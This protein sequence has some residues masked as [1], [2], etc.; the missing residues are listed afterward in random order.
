MALSM[1]LLGRLWSQNYEGKRKKRCGSARTVESRKWD[2]GPR[3]AVEG[4]G[5]PHYRGLAKIKPTGPLRLANQTGWRNRN[6]SDFSGS[7]LT[8]TDDSRWTYKKSIKSSYKRPLRCAPNM[9][10]DPPGALRRS[11][12][13]MRVDVGGSESTC[14]GVWGVGWVVLFWGRKKSVFFGKKRRDFKIVRMSSEKKQWISR[15][16]V[17]HI[18]LSLSLSHAGLQFTQRLIEP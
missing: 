15:L 18:T 9:H 4:T 14:P 17:C 16:F 1:C 11:P 12:A 3:W 10:S 13:R 7:S 5:D 2:D 8:R 6:S